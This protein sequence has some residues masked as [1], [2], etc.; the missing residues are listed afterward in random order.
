MLSNG[1]SANLNFLLYITNAYKNFYERDNQNKLFPYIP[2]N[3]E[4]LLEEKDFKNVL[5][6]HWHEHIKVLNETDPMR[7]SRLDQDFMNYPNF[8]FYRSLF[9]D[10]QKGYET[11]EDVFRSFKSWWDNP[12]SGCRIMDYISGKI[13]PEVGEGI[14]RET[15]RS[16]HSLILQ[17]VYDS[18]P[19]D[20]QLDMVGNYF[21]IESLKDI[22]IRYLYEK[23]R[24]KT[25]RLLIDKLVKIA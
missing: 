21:I 2:M 9:R 24:S 10:N 25:I 18:I 17:V 4:A 1:Y 6:S 8:Y 3:D 12:Y 5:A 16:S 7:L 15:S 11:I 14:Q 22:D 19:S 13:I 23:D 20:F